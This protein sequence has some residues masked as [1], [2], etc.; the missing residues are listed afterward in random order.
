M[1]GHQVKS[2]PP[3]H[4]PSLI[5]KID[6][7]D[8]FALL[9]GLIFFIAGLYIL[10]EKYIDFGYNDWDF[11]LYANAMWNLSHGSF[12]SSTFGTNFLTNHAEYFSFILVPVYRLFGHPFLLIVLKLFSLA[13]GSFLLYLIA[14]KDLGW[15]AAA[16]LMLLYQLYPPN[17][18]M[19]I[20]EFHFENLAIPF[21]FLLYYFFTNQKLV[22]FL[23]TAFFA[24]LI[25]ENI[26]LVVATFGIYAIFSKRENKLAWI[27]GPLFLGGGTFFLSMF[28][29]TPHLRVQEGLNYANQYIGFYWKNPGDTHLIQSILLNLHNAWANMSSPLNMLFIKE[30]LGPLNFLPL[31]SPHTLFLGAPVLLQNFLG[32]T[33]QMHTIYYH[34][35][36]TITVFIFLALAASLKFLKIFIRPLAFYIVVAFTGL[37]CMFNTINHLSEFRGRMAS[38]PDRLDPVRWQMVDVI[39]PDA[40]VMA[41]FDFLDKFADRKDL[42]SFHNVWRNHNPFTGESPYR[43]PQNLSL[44]LIDWECPWFWSDVLTQAR[45]GRQDALRHASDFYF[46]GAWAVKEAT[47]EITLLG[48]GA[49]GNLPP[50]VEVSKDLPLNLP[51]NPVLSVDNKFSLLDFTIGQKQGVTPRQKIPLTFLWKAQEDMDDLY[52]MVI[53]LKKGKETVFRW[54]H[55][56]GYGIYATPL[57]KKGEHVK[58]RYWLL[59]P[60]IFPGE[61]TISVSLANMTTQQGAQLTYQGQSGNAVSVAAFRVSPGKD[62]E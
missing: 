37:I 20:Y 15:P 24:S 31:L 47:E 4:R 2:E 48:K 46:Q 7:P 54:H 45:S 1:H 12:H 57:W 10:V 56:I 33:F 29:I 9:S 61:Y 13:A 25:K 52:S 44:A 50:L 26:A 5:R 16:V 32:P 49:A 36:A 17:L 34:Y 55:H 8:I 51:A 23:I 28:I 30:L 3:N 19:L 43:I 11:A 6:P 38:W 40:S 18:F 58:E 62:V 42:Y 60:V 59:L 27:M 39:P 22:P 41:T 14:K 21:I 53:E 35:A